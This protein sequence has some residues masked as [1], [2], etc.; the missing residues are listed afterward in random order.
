MP[1]VRSFT[2]L[3]ALPESLDELDRLAKN[4]YWSWNPPFIDLF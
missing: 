2:V 1:S 4:V 3:P